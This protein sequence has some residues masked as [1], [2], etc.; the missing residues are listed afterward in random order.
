MRL[1]K[2]RLL[3]YIGIYNG[4]G[5]HEIC[6][7]FSKC[8]HNLCIIKGDNGTGKS[9]LFKA[10]NPLV[11]SSLNYIDGHTAEKEISYLLDDHSILDIHYVSEINKNNGQRKQSRCF[12]HRM[13]PDGR[14]EDVNPS[15]NITS[16]KEEI[17]RLF[18]LN[19]NFML[20]SQ[21]SANKKGIGGLRPAD[22]KRY[23]NAI[24]SSVD[25]YN[26]MHK[27]FSQKSTVVK[28]MINGIMDKLN[29]LGNIQSIK[30][31][32]DQTEKEL[33]SFNRKKDELISKISAV[34]TN[35]DILDKN[36]DIDIRYKDNEDLKIVLMAKIKQFPENVDFDENEFILLEKNSAGLQSKIDMLSSNIE[37]LMGDEKKTRDKMNELFVELEALGD[38][39]TKKDIEDRLANTNQE[40]AK[41]EEAFTKLGF[42]RFRDISK[43]E[44]DIA[45]NAIDKFN[46]NIILAADRFDREIRETACNI[47]SNGEIGNYGKDSIYRND[48]VYMKLDEDK[49]KI[50][51]EIRKI[52]ELKKIS[53]ELANVPA[54]CNHKD[55]CFFIVKVQCAIFGNDKYDWRADYDAMIQ[56]KEQKY[57]NIKATKEALEKEDKR[58]A[59][60]V[61]CVWYCKNMI[62]EIL[63]LKEII[64]KFDSVKDVL[65][66]KNLMHCFECALEIDIDLKTY[67]QY[68]NWITYYK[69]YVENK[70]TLEAE[71]NNNYIKWSAKHD[72]LESQYKKVQE[73]LQVILDKKSNEVNRLN[74]EKK[75]KAEL[76]V[77]LAKL[78]TA[79]DNKEEYEKLSTKLAQCID[80]EKDLSESY[81][82]YMNLKAEYTTLSN[83]LDVVTKTHI[84]GLTNTL[85]KCKYQTI[86]YSQYKESIA[87]YNDTYTKI[88][89]LK[90]YTSI[91]G[92]QTVYMSV[93]MNDILQTTNSLLQY[94]FSGK[95]ALQPFI[96]NENEFSIPCTDLDGRIRP[97]I[98]LMSDSQLSMISMIISFVLLHKASSIYNIIK[99]DEVD[100]NLDSINRMQFSILIEQI[101][102][103]LQFSQCVIISHNNEL[104]MSNSDIILL[105]IENQ[106][107]L[108]SIYNS[109]ANIIYSHVK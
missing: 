68:S 94:L 84:P 19:D 8:R 69:S 53:K 81:K 25:A 41:I 4:M 52:K 50:E 104:D 103:M 67:V 80:T 107:M 62:D 21:I 44:Y 77:R 38:K 73:D 86:L 99:L 58:K 43:I 97:D 79:K 76:D 40:L 64:S 17:Y 49:A 36:G 37:G 88:Q 13:Y 35:M 14:V 39:S 5:L 57:E 48:A 32:Q 55:D 82:S 28:S 93:F 46:N 65:T 3:N 66:E 33:A 59:E 45:L 7:D 24:I 1:L 63:K 87:S 47:I 9:T 6:I 11:D 101:M 100:D 85:E 106:E 60:L 56:E 16:G 54:D 29:R 31:M 12:I 92:I 2:L 15:T 70:K 42:T 22:R 72:S 108:N 20:L 51:E 95:F 105:R 61:D 109:G 26:D 34:K 71:Y 27:L 74:E 89:M 98:S 75:A 91:N 78:R 30:A 10:M 83:E 90:K 102:S 96:I 23:V 18:D